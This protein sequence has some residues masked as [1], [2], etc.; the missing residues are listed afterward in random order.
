[1]CQRIFHIS[2]GCSQNVGLKRYCWLP[3]EL[4]N[5][6]TSNIFFSEE[7]IFEKITEISQKFDFLSRNRQILV[8]FDGQ[9]SPQN[10]KNR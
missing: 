4:K 8:I 2:T 6:A 7:K 10:L 3:S 9:C 1:M 5:C